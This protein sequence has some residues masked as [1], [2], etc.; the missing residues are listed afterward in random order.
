VK[1]EGRLCYFIPNKFAKIEA[2]KKLRAFLTKTKYLKEYTDFGSVQF[3]KEKEKTIYSSIL[4]LEKK[5]QEDFIFREV[6]DGEDWL[7]NDE[8]TTK[9]I[10]LNSSAIT[11][12]P[13][14]LTT[15]TKLI[16]D[17]DHLFKRS[18]LVEDEY[19]VFNG[20]QTSAEQPIPVYWFSDKEIIEEDEKYFKI[21]KFDRQYMI[22]K[23]ILRPYFK[24]NNQ[25]ERQISTYDAYETNKWIIFPYD[26]EGK[27]IPVK[28]M[29]IEYPYTMNYLKDRYEIIVPRQ[30]SGKKSDR[31][32]PYAEGHPDDWYQYGRNQ[33]LTRFNNTDKLIIGVMWRDYPKY[34][35]DRKNYIIASGE[36]AGFCGIGKKKNSQYTLEFLQAYLMHPLIARIIVNRGSNFDKGYVTNGTGIL[37]ALPLIKI[38]FSD[39]DLINRY[40]AINQDARKIY[41][42][43]ERLLH[44][45]GNKEITILTRQKQ[46]L[47]K[48][49]AKNMDDIIY[50]P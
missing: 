1:E 36:T 47:I 4:Y 26:T 20:I 17:M 13:W 44:P 25:K 3:F 11:E 22:E 28:R 16:S 19:D 41:E 37:R 38:D 40:E 24:P 23:S 50:K 15:D 30:I 33:G 14:I 32:V 39:T 12:N 48:K 49:I 42:I 29:D 31:D 27:L 43:N 6:T 45:L 10:L 2:G 5:P 18:I 46:V 34:L 9:S 35:Y 21:N 8:K 7:L